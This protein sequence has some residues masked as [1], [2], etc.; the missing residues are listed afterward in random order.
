MN[1]SSC[2]SDCGSVASITGG[3]LQG[4]AKA[5]LGFCREYFDFKNIANGDYQNPLK[6]R[7][8]DILAEIA[9]GD[10]LR[11][12]WLRIGLSG[13]IEVSFLQSLASDCILDD[14][15][16]VCIEFMAD[17]WNGCLER[18]A[19]SLSRIRAHCDTEV[20]IT[21]KSF[22]ASMENLTPL[23]AVATLKD[24]SIED[25]ALFI[26]L[27]EF[28]CR[29]SSALHVINAKLNEVCGCNYQEEVILNVECV[30]SYAFANSLSFLS[31]EHIARILCKT[32]NIKDDDE[33]F[34]NID[35]F[36]RHNEVEDIVT[37]ICDAILTVS[38]LERDFLSESTVYDIRCLFFLILVF[39]SQFERS[40]HFLKA[41]SNIYKCDYCDDKMRDLDAM[42]SP[43]LGKD[44]E[45]H[46]IKH[47][48][49]VFEK[50]ESGFTRRGVLDTEI[51]LVYNALNDVDFNESKIY[52]SDKDSLD[53]FR[54]R[55]DHSRKAKSPHY[56]FMVFPENKYFDM[57]SVLHE[58][59]PQIIFINK[60]ED[61]GA[62]RITNQRQLKFLRINMSTTLGEEVSLNEN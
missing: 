9:D 43:L 40:D 39:K 61:T 26:K 5:L 23:L 25:R 37:L 31:R 55:F 58:I 35:K 27:D 20:A 2:L 50:P 62:L 14:I 17:D 38:G 1:F 3:S 16:S 12:N 51:N 11:A 30:K 4:V 29:V 52:T 48:Y 56:F 47:Y 32:A 49:Y 33:Y 42:L 21:K 28:E 7:M 13:E 22:L 8:R 6:E 54:S 10:G 59:F 57:S 46:M 53:I 19:D 34:Y 44:F 18:K 36:F 24:L 60:S 15:L 45:P 41:E